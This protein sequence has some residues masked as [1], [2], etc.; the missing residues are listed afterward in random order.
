MLQIVDPIRFEAFTQ[1]LAQP[2]PADLP[3]RGHVARCEGDPDRRSTRLPRILA[4]WLQRRHLDVD[5]VEPLAGAMR[6][7][8]RPEHALTRCAI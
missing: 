2:D 3:H 8:A 6:W 5:P 7:H 1:L 4:A